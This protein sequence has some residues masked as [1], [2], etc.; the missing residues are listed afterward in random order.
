MWCSAAAAQ[1]QVEFS[2]INVEASMSAA[3]NSNALQVFPEIEADLQT[4]I[5]SRVLTSDDASDPTIRIDIRQISL[6]GNPMLVGSND[7]N[8]IQGVVDI[9]DPNNDIGGQ[10][11]PVNIAAYA[12][13]QAIPEGY[14]VIAPSQSDF[15]TAMINGFA[16]SVVAEVEKLNPA[17]SGGKN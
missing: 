16:D 11:F 14:V 7:F 4:A 8:E 12:A 15:Y 17:T 1:E 3:T 5:A 2:D 9:S 13:D 6:N 10:S